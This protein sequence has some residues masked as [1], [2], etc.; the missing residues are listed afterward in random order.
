MGE[1]RVVRD[2]HVIVDGLRELPIG[3]VPLGD[4]AQKEARRV[5][6]VDFGPEVRRVQELL[7]P[8]ARNE[9]DLELLGLLERL[10]GRRDATLPAFLNVCLLASEAEGVPDGPALSGAEFS[11]LG[12]LMR[13][14][15]DG[16]ERRGAD[17]IARALRRAA[18]LLP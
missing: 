17:E 9:L 12:R 11:G 7:G 10:A 3:E 6:A 4:F 16:W 15:A 8:R 5:A 1:Y 2:M 14:H 18:R 13:E